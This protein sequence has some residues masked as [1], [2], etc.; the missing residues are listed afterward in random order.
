MQR[1]K[2]QGFT[3]IELL[4]A[5][6]V[7]LILIGV[8]FGAYVEMMRHT[9]LQGT[10]VGMETAKSMYDAYRAADPTMTALNNLLKSPGPSNQLDM[11]VPGNPTSPPG[12]AAK[13]PLNSQLD[14]VQPYLFLRAC[15]GPR[16]EHAW[17]TI[18]ANDDQ[19]QNTLRAIDFTQQVMRVLLTV[20][21]NREALAKLPAERRYVITDPNGNAID[22]PLLADSYGEPIYF[23]P[24]A[25]LCMS[26]IGNPA[27]TGLLPPYY[28]HVSISAVSG[29]TNINNIWPTVIRSDGR[30]HISPAD[31]PLSDPIAPPNPLP[32]W[33][34]A[35][36]DDDLG[37]AVA[38]PTLPPGALTLPASGQGGAG[39]DNVYSF[40]K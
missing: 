29:A 28:I 11:I 26:G 39:D 32:F 5:I 1:Q 10:N 31:S 7:I 13:Q 24:Q 8:S 6:V 9:H 16:H 15:K 27:G 18:E 12:L 35:G 40:G 33:V 21:E 19:F 23:V 14:L 30:V 3:L 38:D 17:N 37:A 4:I 20:P 34:S 36:P 25:G 2:R 22:P